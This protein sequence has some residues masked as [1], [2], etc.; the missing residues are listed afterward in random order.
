MSCPKAPC[1][2]N[3]IFEAGRSWNAALLFRPNTQAH[4]AILTG[5][6]S[7]HAMRRA[8][9]TTYLNLFACQG[10]ILIAIEVVYGW[11]AASSDFGVCRPESSGE[12]T[13]WLTLRCRP[14][15]SSKGT[16]LLRRRNKTASRRRKARSLEGMKRVIYHDVKREGRFHGRG[17]EYPGPAL[18][19]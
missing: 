6:H 19:H 7:T 1:K 14:R 10:I 5:E 18:Q 2:R 8:L 16:R 15:V 9:E 17:L 3:E 11:F 12:P 13:S 4:E